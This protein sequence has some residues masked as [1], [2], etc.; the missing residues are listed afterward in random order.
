MAGREASSGMTPGSFSRKA[1]L[2]SRIWLKSKRGDNSYAG[3]FASLQLLLKKLNISGGFVVDIAASDGV[4]QS[5][6]LGFF[7]HSDWRGLAVEMDPEKFANLAFIYSQF[8]AVKLARCRVT[9]KNVE[10]LLAGNEVP[11]DF[12]L[13]SL[14]IDSYDLFVMEEMLNAGFKPRIISME[15]N[16]KIPPPVYFT[17]NFEDSHFWKGDHFFGCSLAAAASVVKP[18]G[19]K[20]ESLQYNNAIFVREDI[21]TGVIRDLSVEEAYDL[22]YRNRPDRKELFPWNANV[23]C[24]LGY[25]ADENVRFFNEMFK[26]YQGKFTLV[27]APPGAEIRS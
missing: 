13:L 20:L 8:E 6:T 2:L 3:E 9:P 15:I 22:G 23:E 5:S 18:R 12:T 1:L 21:A 26:Q 10:A 4:T 17:V 14:D 27:A 19:Y 16:E 11:Q 7:S 25:T 24:A